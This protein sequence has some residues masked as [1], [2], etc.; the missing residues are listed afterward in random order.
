MRPPGVYAPQGDTRLLHEALVRAAPPPGARVL[1]V[2]SGTGALAIAAARLGAARVNAVD[3]SARAVLAIRA[4]ARL[5]R[6]PV[7]ACR[8]DLLEPFAGL[9]FDLVLANPPYVPAPHGP[10]PGRGRDRCWDAGQDGRAVI[11]RLCDA[12]PGLLGGGGTLLM[13]HSAL[14]GTGDTLDRLRDG[15]LKAAVVAR[16]RQPFGPVLRAR[17]R[18]LEERGLIEPGQCDEELVVIRA[19]RTALRAR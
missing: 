8:G 18:W 9:R 14:S 5:R 17:A 15:G 4:N 13:V 6:L 3:V 1:D 16:T 12:A 19:D 11:D 10:P 7:N 2:C